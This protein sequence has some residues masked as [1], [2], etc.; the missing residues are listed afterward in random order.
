MHPYIYIFGKQIGTYGLFMA[1]GVLVVGALAIRKGK[2]L[3]ILSEDILIVGSTAVGIALVCGK[4]M[5]I[6]VTYRPA[7]LWLILRTGNFQILLGGGIVFYGGLLGGLLG[8]VLGTKLAGCKAADL[9]E[10]VVPFIPLGHALGRIGCLM[11][12]CCYGMEYDGPC[13]VHYAG[14]VAGLPP[15]QGYFP[16]QL[17]EALLNCGV[18]LF[19]LQYEKRAKRPMDILFTY[20]GSYAVVRF[21][22][23]FF[24]GDSIRGIYW[25]LS[26]SQWISLLLAAWVLGRALKEKI[27][28]E[29]PGGK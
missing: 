26:V 22:L 17:L 29:M 4:L 7:Q 14:S 21:V 12:G 9:V 16:V 3:G 13:A 23:E 20:L 27:Q 11:A 28:A 1:L 10:T 5:Y 24:R 25:G 8:G 2:K 18:C 19:L 6:L 15:T